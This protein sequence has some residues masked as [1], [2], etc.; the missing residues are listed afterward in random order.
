MCVCACGV[1]K[2]GCMG[3]I[4]ASYIE[5][6]GKDKDKGGKY[7]HVSSKKSLDHG[8]GEGEREKEL[9]GGGGG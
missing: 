2:K 6:K 7:D 1:E 4:P 5:E 9:Y 3:Q 8:K